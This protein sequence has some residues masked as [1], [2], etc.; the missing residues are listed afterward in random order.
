MNMDMELYSVPA[1][2]VEWIVLIVDDKLD[3]I[4][5]IRTA[6]SFHGAKVLTA[7]NGQEGLNLLEKTT[8]SFILLDIAMPVMDGW[9]ML[10]HIRANPVTNPIPVIALTAHIIEGERDEIMEA[11]FNGHIQKPV[12]IFTLIPQIRDA[13]RLA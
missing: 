9:Q 5:V 1:S 10:R 3:N 7:A 11:G 8:P 6:L 2:A 12:D 13:L 4:N